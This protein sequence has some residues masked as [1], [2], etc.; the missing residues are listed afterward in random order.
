MQICTDL[1]GL[2]GGTKTRLDNFAIHVDAWDKKVSLRKF[3]ETVLAFIETKFKSIVTA[4]DTC[5][6]KLPNIWAEQLLLLDHPFVSTSIPQDSK[7]RPY[8]ACRL[9]ADNVICPNWPKGICGYKKL[10]L[11]ILS[12]MVLPLSGC[13][14]RNSGSASSS[15]APN[16]RTDQ[17]YANIAT[18]P[19]Q[20][21]AGFAID[22]DNPVIFSYT[23][24]SALNSFLAKR[25][26]FPNLIGWI[27]HLNM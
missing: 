16:I 20:L 22:T 13:M 18:T 26:T 15:M 25:L 24:Q 11:I 27:A 4:E 1:R 6:K 5:L 7:H 9:L 21:Y 23:G 17:L 3:F 10:Q 19:N 2:P 14:G 8:F 12:S